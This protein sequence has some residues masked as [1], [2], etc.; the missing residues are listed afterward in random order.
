MTIDGINVAIAAGGRIGG[1]FA[2]ETGTEVKALAPIGASTILERTIA[3]A[4]DIGARRIVVLGDAEVAAHCDERVERILPDNEDGAANMLACLRA[5]RDD[6]DRSSTL[7]LAGDLPFL[8]AATLRGFI[9]EVAAPVVALGICNGEEY[10]M[11]FPGAPVNGVILRGE[12]IINAGALLVPYPAIDAVAGESTAFFNARK[13]PWR[14]AMRAGFGILV[15]HA[16]GR[17]GVEQI[18]R[19]AS[20]VLGSA[21]A[22]IR[23]CPP[24]LCFD[25]DSL[26]EYRYA[27]AHT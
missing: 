26:D 25:V 27:R 6:V 12:R 13:Y 10:S 14:M 24:E 9:E 3:A 11:R 18:E 23:S 1:A 20:R 22:A 7:L 17:L 2:A 15:A 5:F 19:R 8:D 16:I 4:A 21:V